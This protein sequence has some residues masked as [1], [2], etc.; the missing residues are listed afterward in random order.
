MSANHVADADKLH[1]LVSSVRQLAGS[2]LTQATNV[3]N[4]DNIGKS[5]RALITTQLSETLTHMQDQGS[6]VLSAVKTSKQVY[7][8]L[9][10]LQ[11]TLAETQKFFT[12]LDSTQMVFLSKSKFKTKCRD[13]ANS[14]MAKRTQLFSSVTM[15]LVSGPLRGGGPK[16]P[17]GVRTVSSASTGSSPMAAARG[18]SGSGVADA[19]MRMSGGL[20]VAASSPASSVGGGAYDFSDGAIGGAAAGAATGGVALDDERVLA[21][22]GHSDHMM[23]SAGYAYY[24][25]VGRPRNCS[26]AK[27]RFQEAADVGDADAMMMLVKCYTFGHGV[28]KSM[29]RARHWLSEAVA[30]GNAAAKTE[31]ASLLLMDTLPDQATLQFL[32]NYIA[33]TAVGAKAAAAGGGGGGGGLCGKGCVGTVL[34][35]L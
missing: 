34:V 2:L 28:D 35:T 6:K 19:A 21:M 27:M 13:L 32:R 11:A 5:S 22:H 12:D 16:L 24:Y 29:E 20:S 1:V 33:T 26:L 14:M 4:L 10:S 17:P 30:S 8:N 7:N 9:Q 23:Y 31:L 18:V 15:A 25:G 3:I